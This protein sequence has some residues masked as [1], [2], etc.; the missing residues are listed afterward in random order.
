MIAAIAGSTLLTIAG[1][2]DAFWHDPA[3]ALRGDGL[4]I[5][6]DTNRTFDFFLGHGVSAFLAT[7]LLYMVS[8]F[9][10]VS[11]LPRL[12]ALIAIFS[13]IFAHGY[14]T[15]NWLVVRFHFGPGL[16]IPT[17]GALF[18][19][20][21]SFAVLPTWPHPRA[22]VNAWRW[23]MVGVLFVDCANT[24]IGQPASYWRDPA[25]M[26]EA[27]ALSR[28]F[29]GLGWIY[30]VCLDVVLAA[31]QFALITLLPLPVAFVTGFTFIFASFIGASNWFFYEWRWG[32]VAPVGYGIL[33][34]VALVLLAFRDE[35]T[36][37]DIRAAQPA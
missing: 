27:N 12:P 13:V 33:L 19:V 15:T 18:G 29:L 26:H 32:W 22:A 35:R 3:Q 34:S 25:T 8:A 11:R 31:G 7:N 20:L 28:A 17:C 16:G 5:H 36:R 21:L 14:G 6:A 2:P 37:D 24:L 9:L 23:V 4:P 30:F 10:V 1:Q